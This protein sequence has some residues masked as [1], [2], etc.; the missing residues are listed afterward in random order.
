MFEKRSRIDYKNRSILLSTGYTPDGQKDVELQFDRFD[1]VLYFTDLNGSQFTAD[2]SPYEPSPI[3]DGN[4]LISYIA[5]NGYIFMKFAFPVDMTSVNFDTMNLS[6]GVLTE[7]IGSVE[8]END[9]LVYVSYL[10]DDS[11]P[12]YLSTNF[13]NKVGDQSYFKQIVGIPSLAMFFNTEEELCSYV[14][15]GIN[16]EDFKTI[17]YDVSTGYLYSSPEGYKVEDHQTLIYIP[18]W[19]SNIDGYVNEPFTGAGLPVDSQLISFDAV[20]A[21][22]APPEPLQNLYIVYNE[23]SPLPFESY[24]AACSYF[25]A[26]PDAVPTE[27]E[28]VNLA[29]GNSTV[30]RRGLDWF[31]DDT[32]ETP[33]PT[34]YYLIWY[35]IPGQ[36]IWYILQVTD[37]Q[38]TGSQ[39]LSEC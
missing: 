22:C 16:L 9:T 1:K 38:S 37:G 36:E 5:A 12:M 29:P 30:Y 32:E 20:E 25:N 2:G 8:G 23:S 34:G 19:I 28:P 13:F 7:E 24:E 31:V 18:S 10:N 3:P 35:W 6:G 11:K 26:I 15:G 17:Y 14:G 39:E 21:Y 4:K 27:L 33:L